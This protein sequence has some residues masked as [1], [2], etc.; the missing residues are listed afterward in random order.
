MQEKRE[1]KMIELG[2]TQKLKI[3]R[4]SQF[5]LYLT[6]LDEDSLEEV[7]LPNRFAL[8]TM[9]MDSE[10]EVFVFRDSEDRLTATTQKPMLE[11]GQIGFL[12]VAQKTNFGAFLEWGL[13]KDLFLPIKEQK[14]RAEKD[15]KYLVGLYVDKTNRLCAT[16]YITDILSNQSPYKENDTVTGIIYSV[17]SEIGVFVAVD[18]KY[19]GLIPKKEAQGD[20]RVGEILELRVTK[21]K[22]DGKLD[23]SPKQKAYKQLRTDAQIIIDALIENNGFLPLNDKSSPE[24]VK[25]TLKLSKNSFKR[26]VG[27]LLKEKKIDFEK[28][29]IKLIQI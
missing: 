21:V 5:G 1:V 23:L 16:T 2:K 10:I 13:D 4:R 24:E 28:E 9:E 25:E 18:R 27:N 11:V 15:K 26:A 29:G 17:N 7:L 19:L 20:Y 14:E 3:K 8:D 22:G 6:D 12:K